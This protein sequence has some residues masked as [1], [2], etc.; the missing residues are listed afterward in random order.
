MY[1]YMWGMTAAQIELMTA[2]APF[3]AYKKREKTAEEKRKSYTRDKAERDYERWQ[4]RKKTRKFNLETFLST[5]DMEKAKADAQGKQ[6]N[7]KTEGGG[8]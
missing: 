7:R 3:V 2:D 6:E 8:E 4:Q 1:E 5:G